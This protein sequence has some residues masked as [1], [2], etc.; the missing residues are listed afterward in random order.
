MCGLVGYAGN[1]NAE[2]VLI[3]GL[4]SLEYRGYDSAGIAVIDNGEI[5]IRK[6]KGKI[7]AL[8]RILKEKPVYGTVGIGHTRWAT[9]GEPNQI[10]AHPHTDFRNSIALVH[11]GIIENFQT[12]KNELLSKNHI[13]HSNTDTEV[14]PH[15]LSEF[16]RSGKAKTIKEAM[17]QLFKTI[18]GKWAISL[19]CRIPS[20]TWPIRSSAISSSYR[21]LKIFAAS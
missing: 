3:V 7:K 8:E 2:S 16:L 6:E 15:L 20:T 11:N 13:F 19:C 14:L 12:L 17:L 18:E 10:N 21:R 9:H 4:I 1:K 5:E